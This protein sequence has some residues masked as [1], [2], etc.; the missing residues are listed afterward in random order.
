MGSTRDVIEDPPE[1]D[2]A[3]EVDAQ[4][5]EQLDDSEPREVVLGD[6]STGGA[7]PGGEESPLEIEKEKARGRARGRAGSRASG[8]EARVRH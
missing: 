4:T 5:D 1:V 2:S 7:A 3:S 6:D 8:R